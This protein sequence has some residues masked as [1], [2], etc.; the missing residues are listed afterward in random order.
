M[1]FCREPPHTGK[2]ATEFGFSAVEVSFDLSI[3]LSSG[4]KPVF[5]GLSS[6]PVRLTVVLLHY[7][8]VR[9]GEV[10]FTMGFLSPVVAFLG[11]MIGSFVDF[12][13]QRLYTSKI[14]FNRT[15]PK[16]CA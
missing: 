16:P 13:T 11:W 4:A 8:L 1:E 14:V 10:S 9:F 5:V 2:V 7:R 3:G 15:C 12:F 6:Q